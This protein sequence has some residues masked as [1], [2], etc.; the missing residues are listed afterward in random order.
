MTTI[1]DGRPSC[2]VPVEGAKDKYLIAHERDLQVL[3]WDG[4]SA[5]PSSLKTLTTVEED[6]PKNH[7]NDGKCDPRGR[8]W[9]GTMG[10]ETTPGAVEPERG[11]SYSLDLKVTLKKH[12]DK[13]GISNGLA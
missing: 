13:I 12:V 4:Q 6:R 10:Y 9:T 11:N 1:S 5:A 8:L 7:F 3:E 2:I